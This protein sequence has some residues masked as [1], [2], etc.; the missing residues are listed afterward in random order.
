M[1]EG[2]DSRL[3]SNIPQPA[4]FK[5][6][7]Q[8]RCAWTAD[9]RYMRGIIK[10]EKSE[11]ISIHGQTLPIKFFYRTRAHMALRRRPGN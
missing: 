9:R 1:I 6:V 7:L 5:S 4:A 8:D 10:D 2:L 11:D 3:R